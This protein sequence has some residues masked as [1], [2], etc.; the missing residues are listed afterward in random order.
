MLKTTMAWLAAPISGR[1][2]L[3]VRRTPVH[4]RGRS[5]LSASSGYRDL[6]RGRHPRRRSHLRGSAV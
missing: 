5:D 3:R 1:V 2:G 6:L 4:E